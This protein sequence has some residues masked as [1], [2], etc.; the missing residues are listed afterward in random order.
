MPP[1]EKRNLFSPKRPEKGHLLRWILARIGVFVVLFAVATVAGGIIFKND[2]IFHPTPH[3]TDVPSRFKAEFET[4]WLTTETGEKLKAWYVPAPEGD[5]DTTVIVLQGNSYNMSFL[6]DRL[7]VL[8]SLRV[9]SIIV[10]YH[11]YGESPGAP[12]EDGTYQAAEAAWQWV[13]KNKTA[14]ENIIIY[15]VSLGGGVA[16]WLAEKHPPAGLVLDSTFTR[17]RDVPSLEVPWLAPYL[18]LTL[19]NAYDNEDRLSRIKSPLLVLH[20]KGDKVVPFAMSEK[21]Y[22]GYK[23]GPKK[24]VVGIEGHTDFA[25]SLFENKDGVGY[26]KA[27]QDF[28]YPESVTNADLRPADAPVVSPD[29]SAPG[30]SSKAPEASK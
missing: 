21:L 15:G 8:R 22:N 4:V 1:K 3:Y 7:I 13:A 17:L 2:F 6:I 19:G 26:K 18:Y 27:L 10:D 14:T 30:E 5:A 11:G 20:S 25:L 9:N 12:S 28:L 16:T 23:G 29:I 24:M